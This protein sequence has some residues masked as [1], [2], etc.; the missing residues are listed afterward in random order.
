[1]NE[2]ETNSDKN[3]ES[4]LL[5]IQSEMNNE[6]TEFLSDVDKS[7]ED[8]IN[9][10]EEEFDDSNQTDSDILRLSGLCL[11]HSLSRSVHQLRTKFLDKKIWMPIIDLIKRSRKRRLEKNLLFLRYKRLRLIQIEQEKNKKL[12][13][14]VRKSDEQEDC[15]ALKET[16][17]TPEDDFDELEL[18][19]DDDEFSCDFDSLNE[20]NLLAVTTAILANLLLEFSPS[21]EVKVI[22]FINIYSHLC[23]MFINRSWMKMESLKYWSNLSIIKTIRFGLTVCG[24]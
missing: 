4:I 18:H 11:L 6:S 21:K 24:R 12:E 2:E 14:S 23:K 8:F 16:A 17:K 13:A 7:D 3:I 9:T 5:E 10:L 15:V 19:D 22:R 20:V 1:M